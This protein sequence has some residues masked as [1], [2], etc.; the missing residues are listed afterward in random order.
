MIKKRLPYEKG[1]VFIDFDGCISICNWREA[2]LPGN[3]NNK[4]YD[5]FHSMIPFDPPN[6]WMI[7][8]MKEFF[9]DGVKVIILTGRMENNRNA[10]EIWLA[11]NC[12]SYSW[13]EMRKNNDFRSSEI[14]KAE[15]VQQYYMA[16]VRMI[17]DD[18]KKIIE[19]FKTLGYPTFRVKARI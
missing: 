7:G 14:F 16:E 11:V 19:H 8:M 18:R 3:S 15:C 9:N 4:N 6:Q 13:M 17:F 12:V 5:A 2:L 1:V 10:S